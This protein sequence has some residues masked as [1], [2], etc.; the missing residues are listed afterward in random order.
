MLR[1]IDALA[2]LVRS[3]IPFLQQERS[4]R[5][6]LLRELMDRADV[7]VAEKYRRILEAY[8]IEMDY[9]RT[10]EA[11]RDELDVDGAKRTVDL[12]RVGRVGLY[13][14]SLDG[15]QAGYWDRDAR[16]W[17]DVDGADR[18]AIR[19]ALRIA[20]KQAAPELLRVQIPAPE[21]AGP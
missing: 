5:V 14:Q 2:Q 4:Q 17:I 1:M 3:D 6:V 8:Q 15:A 9:G 21:Q 10:L 20:R 7:A 12:V 11:Y 16:G 13:Y 19:Q 18:L